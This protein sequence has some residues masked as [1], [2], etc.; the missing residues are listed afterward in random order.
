MSR[1]VM[2]ADEAS[3]EYLA[4]PTADGATELRRHVCDECVW[5]ASPLDTVSGDGQTLR[6]LSGCELSAAAA[7]AD[8]AAP[9]PAQID[10]EFGTYASLL[11]PPRHTLSRASVD[12]PL[13]AG[14][15]VFG[16]VDAPE[17]LP[18]EYLADLETQG[19]TI[20]DGCMSKDMVRNV[21]AVV[22]ST[23]QRLLDDPD[24]GDRLRNAIT[25]THDSQLHF[26]GPKLGLIQQTPSVA[27]SVTHPVALY[28]IRSYLGHECHLGHIPAFSLMR[29]ARRVLESPRASGWHAVRLNNPHPF[30]S[31]GVRFALTMRR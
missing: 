29:P 20:L 15:R 17:R 28:L 30:P 10:E 26:M 7:G 8:P 19:Y 12:D 6:S 21:H 2:L 13:L 3:G 14:G 25:A 18:S 24:T 4:A 27:R 9:T 11:V 5:T 16:F 22:E 31:R 23:K 1:R